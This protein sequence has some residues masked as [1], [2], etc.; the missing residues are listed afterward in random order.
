MRLRVLREGE[1]VPHADFACVEVGH[2]NSLWL[3]TENWLLWKWLLRA[4]L[5][6]SLNIDNGKWTISAV[7]F[8]LN[9]CKCDAKFDAN[10]RQLATENGLDWKWFLWAVL[11]IDNGKWTISTR[12][13]LPKFC[14]CDCTLRPVDLALMW[15]TW[16]H[17][18]FF[19]LFLAHINLERCL[20]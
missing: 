7:K 13:I 14:K 20:F 2:T 6:T 10:S 5:H 8:C 4:V 18:P 17:S 12:I 9:L 19:S 11:H 3:A 1:K 15:P 16:V